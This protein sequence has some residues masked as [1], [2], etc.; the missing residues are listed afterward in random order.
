ME[1]G[2]DVDHGLFPQAPEKS[3]LFIY[4]NKDN[5]SSSEDCYDCNFVPFAEAKMVPGMIL[6]PSS[7][8]LILGVK[9]YQGNWW[10]WAGTQWIGYV[11]GSF[12]GGH[13]ISAESEDVYGEVFDARIGSN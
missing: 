1:L 3:H 7:S 12:W 8:K 13:F 10:V 11:P 6:E 4:V 5:Y 9:Y 2:I